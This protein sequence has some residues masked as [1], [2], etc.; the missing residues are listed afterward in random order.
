MINIKQ[1]P[2]LSLYIHFPWCVR[3]CPYCDFNSHQLN[4]Q[5]PE[6]NYIAALLADLEQDLPLI[7]DRQIQTIFMGGGTPSLFSGAAMRSLFDGLR[8]RV[9]FADN[10]EITLEAN[11]GTIE[12]QRFAQYRSSGINRLSLGIQSF[13]DQQLKL[14]GRIHDSMQAKQAIATAQQAGFENFNL[15]LM[16]GLADQSIQQALTDLSMAIAHKP[17]HISWYQL[18]IEP[19]TVFYSKP[20]KLPTDDYIWEMQQQG[21][22]LL[23]EHGYVQ[24]EVSAYAKNNLQCQHNR[25]YWQFGDYLGIGAGAHGKITQLNENKIL[26]YSKFKQPN[27]Y[28]KPANKFIASKEYLAQEDLCFEFMLNALRLQEPIAT[29]MFLQRTG[30][31]YENLIFN[32]YAATKQEL[33]EVNENEIIT[34]DLG[35]RFLNDLVESFLDCSYNPD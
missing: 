8:E 23:S 14:L 4:G 25:N 11:P 28:L 9:S 35:K 2:P 15:D 19:N 20:P 18:T 5:L 32:S 29:E 34:T 1:L 31:E 26:R 16:F 24:Y 6:E 12:Q 7:Q 30:L 13:A 17:T 3:K 21:K 22:T 10:I 27:S 33:L